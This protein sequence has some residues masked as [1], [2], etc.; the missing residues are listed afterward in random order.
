[1]RLG[2]VSERLPFT[3]SFQGGTPQFK[4]S[5]GGLT[6]GFRTLPPATFSVRVGVAKTAASF[7]PVDHSAVRRYS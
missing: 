4:T 7:Y 6:S 1:M 5:A 3:V 2:V